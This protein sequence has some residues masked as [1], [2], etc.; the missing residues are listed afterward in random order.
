MCHFVFHEEKSDFPERESQVIFARILVELDC[1]HAESH[2]HKN[3]HS[4][5]RYIQFLGEFRNGNALFAGVADFVQNAHV[6][7]DAGRLETEGGKCNFLSF[8]LC[9]YGIDDIIFVKIEHVFS[10][11]KS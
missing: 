7:E 6:S 9:V 11:A 5:K 8:E 10:I 4:V 1:S 2:L 3:A